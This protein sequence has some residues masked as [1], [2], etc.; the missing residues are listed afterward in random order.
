MSGGAPI[1]AACFWDTASHTYLQST[2]MSFN[3]PCPPVRSDALVSGN[4][5]ALTPSTL[6]GGIWQTGGQLQQIR[7]LAFVRD[8]YVQAALISIDSGSTSRTSITTLQSSGETYPSLLLSRTNDTTL[9]VYG[10]VAAAGYVQSLWSRLVD[11]G[12]VELTRSTVLTDWAGQIDSITFPDLAPTTTVRTA[13]LPATMLLPGTSVE[14]QL[15][16][17]SNLLNTIQ[18]TVCQPSSWTGFGCEIPPFGAAPEALRGFLTDVDALLLTERMVLD[19]CEAGWDITLISDHS[20]IQFEPPNP[21]VYDVALDQQQTYQ[22]I[23]YA[24]DEHASSVLLTLTAPLDGSAVYSLNSYSHSTVASMGA[25]GPYGA[26]YSNV[27][28]TRLVTASIVSVTRD[29]QGHILTAAFT[30]QPAGTMELLTALPPWVDTQYENAT[31]PATRVYVRMLDESYGALTGRVCLSDQW[32]DV[33]RVCHTAPAPSSTGPHGG[34]P[35]SSSGLTHGQIIAIAFGAAGGAILLATVL[36][37]CV[38][39]RRR[40]ASLRRSTGL[41]DYLDPPDTDYRAIPANAASG[42]RGIPGSGSSAS[43]RKAL[44]IGGGSG[45]QGSPPSPHLGSPGRVMQP[46]SYNHASPRRTG[47]MPQQFIL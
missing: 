3:K 17:Q 30:D 22:T 24:R 28:W 5:Y 15:L 9:P 34:D 38:R 32:D 40:A 47:Q 10:K 25:L 43:P 44:G 4:S 14:V 35:G 33:Q 18:T 41:D 12:L 13:R 46:T 39:R 21:A 23:A 36:F 1:Y 2:W 7:L 6:N 11:Q 8:E 31:Y 19:V 37:C 20:T 45:L 29:A 27:L 26:V 16:D 42:V